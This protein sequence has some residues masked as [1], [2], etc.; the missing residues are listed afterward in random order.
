VAGDDL[1]E[2]DDG[3]TVWRFDRTFLRSN[4]TCIWGQ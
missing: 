2:I 3:D 1:E 4:W